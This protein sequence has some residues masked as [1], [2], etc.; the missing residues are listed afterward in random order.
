MASKMG[1]RRWML[2]LIMQLGSV[3]LTRCPFWGCFSQLML[4]AE[5]AEAR[6][7]PDIPVPYLY[8]DMGAAVLCASFMSFGVKR[9]WFAL[10]AALQLAISTYAAYVGGYVHY[11]DWLKMMSGRRSWPAMA[12]VLL[13]LLVC[14][15]ELVDAY[16]A[17]PQ[18]PGEHASPDELNRYYTSLRHYL[19]LVTR[20]R[21][22]KRDFSEALL[23]ILLFPDR[24]DPPVK[25]RPEGD[26]LW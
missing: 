3:L 14:L 8:F 18:A 21:F 19:N 11:G 13:T 10:G 22:G 15:G 1:S 7:K 26:Y 4:Y 25:S 17:K 5:R 12:T 9:R 24:E 20:Q 16:P 2:Q 23:S 6:R